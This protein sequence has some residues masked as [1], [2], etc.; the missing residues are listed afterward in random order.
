[1]T[2][3]KAEKES[4]DI[5]ILT[6]GNLDG[7]FAAEYLRGKTYAHIIAADRGLEAC[8]ALGIVPTDILGDFDSIKERNL[9][10]EYE[11]KGIPV[12]TYPT[13]KD[14][15]DTHLAVEY[16][17]GLSPSSV[18]VLGATGSRMD[19][20]LANLSMLC[21]LAKAGIWGKIVD[22]HNEIEMLCGQ[23]E[24]KYSPS[25]DKKYISLLAWGGEAK[26]IDLEGFAYPLKNASMTPDVSL[27]V[28][29]EI[30]GTQG[31]LRMREGNLLVI[32]SS[33]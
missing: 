10:E 25:P 4:K 22:S 9:L 14:Y 21:L 18:T 30:E 5:L 33:D 7:E 26:G 12:R 20:T 1:M 29:N 11:R 15:T 27:G 31:I 24:R 2:V 19:H 17:I 28:S 6:G 13:R 23:V 16:A 3:R 32:R 8:R